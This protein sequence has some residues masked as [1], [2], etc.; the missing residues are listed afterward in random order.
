MSHKEKKL[1]L[2]VDDI[3]ANLHLAQTILKNF[4]DVSLAK[5][6]EIALNILKTVPVDLILVDIEMPDMTG[7]EFIERVLNDPK[8]SDIPVIFVS[9]HGTA[10]YIYQAMSVGA[11]DFIVKPINAP[12]LL[13]KVMTI[14]E[15]ASKKVPQSVN[16]TLT[17]LNDACKRGV[18]SEIKTYVDR[19][20]NVHVNKMTDSMLLEITKLTGQLDYMIASEKIEKILHSNFFMNEK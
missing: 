5:S 16:E 9:S 4:Y 2:V 1:I 8:T 3:V 11:R 20:R 13:Q 10:E 18:T 14:F 12:T 6:A 7:L 19:L 15:D 17:L